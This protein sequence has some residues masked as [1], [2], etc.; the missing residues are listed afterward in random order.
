MLNQNIIKNGS[1]NN[2]KLAF[3]IFDL[4]LKIN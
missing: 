2:L 1:I 3:E 4:V